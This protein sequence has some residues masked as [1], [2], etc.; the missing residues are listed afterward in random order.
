MMKRFGKTVFSVVLALLMTCLSLVTMAFAE[1]AKT[2]DLV[3]KGNIVSDEISSSSPNYSSVTLVTPTSKTVQA[4]KYTGSVANPGSYPNEQVWLNRGVVK[5]KGASNYYNCMGFAMYFCGKTT[6][7][8]NNKAFWLH[9]EGVKNFFNT[10]CYSNVKLGGTVTCDQLH[11]KYQKLKVG[12]IVCYKYPADSA[13]D[14]DPDEKFSHVAVVTKVTSSKITVISKWG[15]YGIYEHD[16]NV[17]PWSESGILDPKMN[18]PKMVPTEVEVWHCKHS[19]NGATTDN[20]IVP[21]KRSGKYVLP[22]YVD[23]NQTYHKKVC[24]CGRGYTYEKHSTVNGKCK[25]CG[26]VFSN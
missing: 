22:S 23:Y 24:A 10:D 14:H 13:A 7:I 3:L 26:H 21:T 2:D 12:D 5:K 1:Q 18:R 8:T 17:C 11:T 25:R 16:V 20:S 4:Y 15:P 6:N 19:E 9:Y